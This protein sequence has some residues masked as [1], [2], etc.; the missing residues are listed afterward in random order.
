MFNRKPTYKIIKDMIPVHLRICIE[1]FK[2]FDLNFGPPFLT[3]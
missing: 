1:P 2:N 3:T